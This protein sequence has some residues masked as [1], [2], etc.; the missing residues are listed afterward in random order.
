MHEVGHAHGIRHSGNKDNLAPDG[1]P[2]QPLM[3][4]SPTPNVTEIRAD[5][6]AQAFD[7]F[8]PRATPNWGFEQ[9]LAY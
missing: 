2:L 8:G 6:A 3:A 7:R 9:D 5:D 1:A 4:C